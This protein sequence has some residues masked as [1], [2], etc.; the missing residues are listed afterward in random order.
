MG[1]GNWV[2]LEEPVEVLLQVTVERVFQ[3]ADVQL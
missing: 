2:G 1:L 3:L